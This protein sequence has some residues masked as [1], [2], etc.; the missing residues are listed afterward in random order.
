MART[1]T[2]PQFIEVESKVIGAITARQFIILLAGCIFVG[3]LYKILRFWPFVI[4][5][6]FIMTVC[7]I[8]AFAKINGRAFHY[9]VLNFIQTSKRPNLRIWNI[10]IKN[11]FKDPNLEDLVKGQKKVEFEKAVYSRSRLSE[12]T[13]MVDTQGVYKGEKK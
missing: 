12:L 3:I 4:S 6:I 1:F 10:D 5:A 7:G 8:F 9:F 2:V 11:D 13:L